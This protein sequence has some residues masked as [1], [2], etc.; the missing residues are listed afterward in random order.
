[1]YLSIQQLGPFH[2]FSERWRCMQNLRENTQFGMWPCFNQLAGKTLNSEC[3]L[4]SISLQRGFPIGLYPY[5]Y[6]ILMAALTT[7]GVPD[8]PE[9]NLS[10]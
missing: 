9:G 1:M 10:R 5:T 6:D 3:G 7:K 2:F 8:S 4:A